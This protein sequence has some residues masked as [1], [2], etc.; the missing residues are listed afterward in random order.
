MIFVE[1]LS[2]RYIKK[3][4]VFAIYAIYKSIVVCVLAMQ[5]ISNRGDKEHALLHLAIYNSCNNCGY[6]CD[7][8]YAL[9]QLHVYMCACIINN[10][11]TS[12][13][14]WPLEQG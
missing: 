5:C 8:K 9:L 14:T 2:V 4:H 3:E 11:Q 13:K 1:E 12:S 10:T 6:Q 7:N